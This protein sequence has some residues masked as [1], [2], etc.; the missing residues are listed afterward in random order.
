[1][2]RPTRT[3]SVVV[4][5]LLCGCGVEEAAP[6]IDF[7]APP[8]EAPPLVD[9]LPGPTAASP[10]SL[11]A[12]PF[13]SAALDDA[14]HAR[15]WGRGL[16]WNTTPLEAAS[17]P[18][19]CGNPQ[20]KYSSVA[21]GESTTCGITAAGAVMCWGTEGF[22]DAHETQPAAL[23]VAV[24]NGLV[25]WVLDGGAVACR[26]TSNGPGKLAEPATQVAVGEVLACARLASGAV[27]CWG[28][29]NGHG[30][31]AASARVRDAKSVAVG[32]NHAC[33]IVAA[34]SADE[35]VCWG[36]N[37]YGQLGDGTI[38]DRH[39]PVRIGGSILV[40]P[41][42]IAAGA[43]TTCALTRGGAV[44]CWGWNL[45]GQIGDGTV[46]GVVQEYPGGP[47]PT[48]EDRHV[49]TP[50]RG[51]SR[52]VVAIT[53]GGYTGMA[54]LASGAIAAW[55]HN[56]LGQVGDGTKTDRPA[57]VGIAFP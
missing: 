32:Y 39:E 51:L 44:Y 42:A 56:N 21:A 15:C 57:P 11:S 47:A 40:D 3:G 48:T 50:V 46:G 28:R 33:A 45:Y 23:S 5:L 20:E 41:I 8:P 43:N 16:G 36:G 10:H 13:H 49:P 22:G 24:G 19:A 14:G 37:Y 1:M 52:G 18:T 30:V 31:L 9:T 54:T 27:S 26:G 53:M 38:D 17:K 2:N 7:V 34:G 12:G 25:C 29:D 35:V 55:G 4:A 6:K